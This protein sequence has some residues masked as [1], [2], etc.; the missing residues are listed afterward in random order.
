MSSYTF[1][2]A[3]VCKATSKAASFQAKSKRSS[4]F[5]MRD[6]CKVHTQHCKHTEQESQEPRTQVP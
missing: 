1:F 2:K 4:R 5:R 6:P 3:N